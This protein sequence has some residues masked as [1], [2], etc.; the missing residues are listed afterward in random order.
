MCVDGLLRTVTAPAHVPPQAGNS[1]AGLL[2]NPFFRETPVEGGL[3]IN[4]VPIGYLLPAGL[5]CALAVY[6]RGRR[7]LWY[8]G[9]AGALS[10]AL[11]DLQR[12]M[13]SGEPQI[14]PAPDR[15]CG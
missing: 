2:A 7:P 8:W 9:G 3:V 1:Q 15:R 10:A 11:G 4:A 13:A 14:T 12:H 5:A 6:A